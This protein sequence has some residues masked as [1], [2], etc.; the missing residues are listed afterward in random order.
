MVPVVEVDLELLQAEATTSTPT[1]TVTATAL[2]NADLLP[3]R[4]VPCFFIDA[5][6]GGVHDP[7]DRGSTL[8]QPILGQWLAHV[9]IWSTILR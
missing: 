6:S 3:Q 8:L 5:P 1:A 2:V 4:L 7:I 9:T